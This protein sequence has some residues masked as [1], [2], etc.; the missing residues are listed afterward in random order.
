MALIKHHF[1]EKGLAWAAG[2]GLAT[3]RHSH[4]LTF[5][6]AIP[7]PPD[8]IA[9]ARATALYGGHQVLT[10]DEFISLEWLTS[11]AKSGRQLFMCHA[12]RL[13]EGWNQLR[14]HPGR[15][16]TEATILGRL[17]FS[18][19]QCAALL[20]QDQQA[21]LSCAMQTQINRLL[22]L[23]TVDA[24]QLRIKAM[25]LLAAAD[26][27]Q[28]SSPLHAEAM[29]ILEQSLPLLIASDG[30]PISDT[31]ADYVV[32]TQALLA[33]PDTAFTPKARNALDRARP[34]LA[35]LLGASGHFCFDAKIDPITTIQNT[36]P[37][38]LAPHSRVAHLTAGKIV[39]I[40]TPSQLHTA[41]Q[42]CIS[43]NSRALLEA[44]L[45]LHGPD[46]DQTVKILES[47]GD[48]QGQWFRQSTRDQLRTVFLCA[49]GDDIR[50]ED[51]LQMLTKPNWMHLTI[52]EHAKVSVARNGT[53][54][55]IALDGKNL[56]QLT[57]RGA[58]L[59]APTNGHQWLA[60]ATGTRVNWALK[61]INRSAT[62]HSKA[63][64]PELP[65]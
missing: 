35:M 45:F 48:D 43:G 56:W 34:F 40:T 31:L 5:R 6:P 24:T 28:K 52:S 29:Q 55:T 2:M 59:I 54:A 21:T 30:G 38:R 1:V 37:L 44:G 62:R 51:Q 50:I 17:V 3:P 39:V 10:A 58:E 65:F 60:K 20:P 41:T 49:K 47:D 57:L 11:F 64:V 61:R 15:I 63:E 13:L 32:W 8:K 4:V 19:G 26:T 27:Q 7:T 22:R 46:D 14:R 42:L 33:N 25:A 23:K 18:A 12:L 9:L 16:E 36:A 53:Q